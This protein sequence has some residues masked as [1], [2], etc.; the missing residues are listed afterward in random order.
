M[1][2]YNICIHTVP[3]FHIMIQL[4]LSNME[5]LIVDMSVGFTVG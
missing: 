1:C 3:E 4:S 2:F 5:S